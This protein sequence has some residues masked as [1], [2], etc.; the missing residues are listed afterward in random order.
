MKNFFITLCGLFILLGCDSKEKEARRLEELRK[1]TFTTTAYNYTKFNLYNIMYKDASVR[2][3]IDD[4]ADGGSVFFRGR[5]K[6]NLDNGREIPSSGDACCVIWSKPTDRPLRI[7]VV[8]S[9]IYDLDAFD[10]KLDDRRDKRSFK[11]RGRGSAW[12]EAVVDVAPA[13]ADVQADRVV[14]HFLADGTIRANL[15]SFASMQPLSAALVKQHATTLPEGEYCK[16]E[17][18]NPFYGIPR[19]PHRE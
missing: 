16:R 2:F 9:V 12:C 5:N 14:F 15:E 4:A 17:I 13:S 19:K 1:T 11:D 18:D 10:G 8:W 6:V 7:R 3:D